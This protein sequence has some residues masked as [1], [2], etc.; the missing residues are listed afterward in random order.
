MP[1][2]KIMSE[3]RERGVLRK[4]S[5][6]YQSNVGTWGTPWAVE[7]LLLVYRYV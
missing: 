2:I 4:V 3:M 1:F 5:V 6:V 7:L